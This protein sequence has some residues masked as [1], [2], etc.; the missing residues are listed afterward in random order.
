MKNDTVTHLV[1]GRSGRSLISASATCRYCPA[2]ER[3]KEALSRPCPRC[4]ARP[5]ETCIWPDG[6][7][8]PRPHRDR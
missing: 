7:R 1:S 2:A 8:L 5:G 4:G 6:R 3:T